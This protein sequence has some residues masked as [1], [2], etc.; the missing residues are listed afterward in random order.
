M[1]SAAELSAL[2]AALAPTTV[3]SGGI[4]VLNVRFLTIHSGLR[5]GFQSRPPAD[6]LI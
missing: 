5:A 1:P 6:D 2:D 4:V 3:A